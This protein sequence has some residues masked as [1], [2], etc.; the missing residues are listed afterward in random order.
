MILIYIRHAMILKS[1]TGIRIYKV[2]RL[3]HIELIYHL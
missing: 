3:F 1:K 2:V